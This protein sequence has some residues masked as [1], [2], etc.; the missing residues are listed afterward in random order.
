MGIP[1]DL[2]VQVARIAR[3]VSF[4][5][6][7][8]ETMNQGGEFESGF[9]RAPG[10]GE[11]L[12]LSEA[13]LVANTLELLRASDGQPYRPNVDYWQEPH[14]FQNLRMP[15][16]TVLT[17]EYLREDLASSGHAIYINGVRLPQRGSL[18]ITGD[19]VGVDNPEEDATEAL[20]SGESQPETASPLGLDNGWA[21]AVGSTGPAVYY[22]DRQ[23]AYLQ[24][25][26]AGGATATG[27]V[28]FV[29]PAE[30]RSAYECWLHSLTDAGPVR[31][32]V[33][34]NGEVAIGEGPFEAGNAWLSLDG[35]SFRLGLSTRRY[36]RANLYPPFYPRR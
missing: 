16:G 34:T 2:G 31:L 1:R 22:K 30:C 29:L 9:V 24:G 19:V 12:E 14:G 32:D 27:T 36:P 33:R 8:G 26:I 4:N 23:R 7:S 3:D 25:V 18:R 15:A 6:V 17:A 5:Q 21:Q 20:L 13:P 11:S 35:L 28:L 10:V